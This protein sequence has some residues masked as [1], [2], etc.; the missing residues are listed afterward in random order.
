VVNPQALSTALGVFLFPAAGRRTDVH[1]HHRE[2]GLMDWI[3]KERSTQAPADEEQAAGTSLPYLKRKC[4][5]RLA[6]TSYIIPADIMPNLRFL[7]PHLDEV[8]IVLFESREETNL[9]SPEEIREMARVGADLDFSFNIHLPSDLFF[10]D[11]DPALRDRFHQTALRFYERT[12]PLDPTLYVL[13]LDSRRADG[14]PE[15]DG[16]AWLE[17]V[18]E[19]V[20]RLARGGIDL[21]RVAVENLEYPLQ[22]ILPLAES[23]HMPFCLDMGHLLR[24]GY[25]LESTIAGFLA[26]SA[27]VH[28]HG[29]KDGR[30]H[31]G[32]E[33]IPQKEWATIKRALM[34]YSGGV[35]LEVFSL[36]DLAPS[37][38]RMQEMAK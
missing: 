16:E 34:D 14:S 22:R 36:A 28:L 2:E 24:Y 19:S 29:V 20:G 9:P 27:M 10:G 23:F 30:D 5:F 25:D 26:K 11:P 33:W 32:I 31:C 3:E 18:W 21:G 1:Y 7:G 12:L 13:H 17:R 38:Q 4:A 15:K 6:T 35:S 37:L 8:E